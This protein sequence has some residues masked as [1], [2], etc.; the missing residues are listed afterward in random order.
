M[1]PVFKTMFPLPKLPALG[2]QSDGLGDK[3]R[4]IIFMAEDASRDG[5]STTASRVC[6]AMIDCYTFLTQ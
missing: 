6:N 3:E 5:A 4:Q 2:S 1:S